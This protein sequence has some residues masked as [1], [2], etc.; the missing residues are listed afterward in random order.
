MAP[1]SVMSITNITNITNIIVDE[2]VQFALF[3]G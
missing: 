2:A 1:Q 3:R